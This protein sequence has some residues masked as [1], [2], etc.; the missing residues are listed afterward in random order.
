MKATGNAIVAAL[1]AIACAPLLDLAMVA[2]ADESSQPDLSGYWMITFG[3]LPP[4]REPTPLERSLIERLPPGTVLLG[5]S[6]LPE[7]P[8]GEFGGLEVLEGA[9]DAAR[10]YDPE[11][12]RSVATTCRPP[13]IIY[14]M[15]G[16]FPIEIFQGSRLI[17]MKLEYFDLVRIVFMDETDHP[18]DWPLTVTGHSIGHWE[19]D[20]LV[21]DTARLQPATLLNN[22]LDHTEHVRLLERF[23]LSEDGS[24]LAVTQ[25]IEDPQ[26]FTGRA[27]RVLSLERGDGHVYPYACDPS[28]GVAIETRDKQ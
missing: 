5:D 9:L 21:V 16:P 12:Q 11:V 23:R 17:V 6:G 25:E 8:P 18:D 19:G 7:F 3:A 10:R 20:T 27:A 24:T 2:S 22:G 13:G 26:V 14:S 28:Y 15:Q 4:R 1:G